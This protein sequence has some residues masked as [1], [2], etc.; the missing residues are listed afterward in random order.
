MELIHFRSFIYT[1]L[2]AWITCYTLTGCQTRLAPITENRFDTLTFGSFVEK[3]FPFIS[4]YLDVRNLGEKFSDDNVVARGLII[5]LED[6]AF[7]CFDRDLLRW[8]VAWTGAHLTKSLLPQVSYHDFFNK[9]NTI[10]QIAGTPVFTNG[11]Y[12]GWSIGESVPRDYRPESQHREGFTWGPLPEDFGRWEGVYVYEDKVILSYRVKSTLVKELPGIVRLDNDAVFLRS[13]QLAPSDDTLYLHL[14]EIP[15]LRSWQIDNN[16]ISAAGTTK[17]T[18]LAART[19]LVGAMIQILDKRYLSVKI[20]PSAHER[21]FCVSLWRGLKKDLPKFAK[22]NLTEK[23][24]FPQVEKGA[25]SRWPQMVETKGLV[26]PDTTAFVTDIMTLPLPNPWKRNVRV[27]DLAFLSHNSAV[28]TTFEGDVW[29]LEGI[30]SKLDRLRW[31]RF[32][33][34]L[35]EPMSV[36]VYKDQIYVFGKEGIIR[37][38]DFNNDGEADFYENFSDIMQQSAESYEWAADMIFSE[39]HNGILIARGGALTA[40][41]GIT[42]TLT[43]GFRAGSNHSGSILKI[44]FDGRSAEVISTGFRAPYLGLHPEKG[45]LTATD[46]QGNYVSS[47]P[48]FVVNQGDF[49]GVPATAHRTDY[50]EPKPPLTWIPHRIDRSAGSQIWAVNARLGPLNDHLV[51]LSFGKPGLFRVLIDSVGNEIQGGVSPIPVSLSTPVLK[52]TVG[53]DGYLYL[54]GF[55]LF[56]SSSKGVSAIQRIRYNEMPFLMPNSLKIGRQGIIIKFLDPIDTLVAANPAHYTVKR[57]NYKRTD[58]YGSGHFKSDG[59]PGEERIP[60]S[61]VYVSRDKYSVLLLIPDM[62]PVDQLEIL[63]SAAGNGNQPITVGIWM[64]VKY[65]RDLTSEFTHFS[66]VELSGIQLTKRDLESLI[67]SDPPIT[68][69]Y[70]R[71]LFFDL[72]CSGCHSPGTETAG[73]YGPPFKGLYESERTLSDGSKVIADDNYL[74]ESILRPEAK[75]VMGFESE[76]PSFEGIVSEADMEALILYI[77]YLKY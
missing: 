23:T 57:W 76:M 28:V 43:N 66:G 77:M 61:R 51:H 46:Q 59:T 65:L 74:K 3:D 37:L 68:R 63:Y 27:T 22:I 20:P 4:T 50:P 70:G 29:I 45:I 62:K 15:D 1:L 25:K 75:V 39:I 16:V 8:S 54:A 44:S 17:D 26:S 49:F 10:P 48:I 47:T 35:Y 13:F 71:K 6:S 33:S 41:P 72:G 38:H 24:L 56:G 40:R 31:K 11:S 7:V 64:T 55:N 2:T 32:A 9:K 36:E 30:S 19:N 5:H 60:V 34:G 69:E 42:K 52:G 58:Q 21:Q 73:M 12:A 18:V 14:T 53:P 67:Q